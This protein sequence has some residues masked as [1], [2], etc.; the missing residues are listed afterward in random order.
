MGEFSYGLPEWD[1]GVMWTV[2]HN[3]RAELARFLFHVEPETLTKHWDIFLP[4]YL[5]TSDQ[6]TLETYSRRLLPFY[7]V[8]VPYVY[9]MAY[10]G[11]MPD[12]AFQRLNPILP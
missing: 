2:C 1:L 10:H 3:M 11:R 4:A 7:A 9:D 12:A 5:G 6:Q 8:K